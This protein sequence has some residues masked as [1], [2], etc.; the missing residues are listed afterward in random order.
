MLDF[1]FAFLDRKRAFI[2]H[3]Y[4]K[5]YT[6]YILR[7][8]HDIL[9]TLIF[10]CWTAVCMNFPST[11]HILIYSP[12]HTSVHNTRG[13]RTKLRSSSNAS[14]HT[15]FHRTKTTAYTS[16]RSWRFSTL[17]NQHTSHS[18]IMPLL[19]RQNATRTPNRRIIKASRCN[20]E[21]HHHR[22][23]KPRV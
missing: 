19:P 17:Y 5:E 7:M 20:A 3:E 10:N 1:P 16:A 15:F 18:R 9:V 11:F 22:T 12:L 2:M 4:R 13:P 8:Y 21:P 23:I 14:I 6:F